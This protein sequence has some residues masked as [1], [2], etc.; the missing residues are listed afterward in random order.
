MIQ[1]AF[2]SSPADTSGPLSLTPIFPP[3]VLRQQRHSQQLQ[4]QLRL[5]LQQRYGDSN[6]NIHAYTYSDSNCYANTNTDRDSNGYCLSK[7]EVFLE[8]SSR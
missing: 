1:V 3:T 4:L 6:S 7:V 2:D 8:K 5:R